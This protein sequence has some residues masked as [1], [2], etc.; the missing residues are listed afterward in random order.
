MKRILV[1][2][3]GVIADVYA[4]FFELHERETGEILRPEDIAGLKEADAFDGQ[5]RWVNTPG[6]F[7]SVP[8]MKDSVTVLE[9]LNREY[10]VII[11]SMAT[12]FPTSLNDKRFWLDYHFPFITWQQMVFCGD[13]RLINADIMIDDHF[14]NLDEFQGKTILFTQPH[15]MKIRDTHHT[16]VDTWM[17]IEKLLLP[18]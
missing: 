17:E 18:L 3:D 1:D 8:V 10:E 16:R 15:N 13:K 5:L 9:K 4:K 7:R 14:K 12:E 6:F 11:V 2:M